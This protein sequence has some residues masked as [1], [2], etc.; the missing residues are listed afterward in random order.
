[1]TMLIDFPGRVT[2]L[3]LAP[4]AGLEPL[5]EAISNAL[6]AIESRSSGR[7]SIRIRV[8][9]DSTAQLPLGDLAA[10]TT[11][12]IEDTGVGFTDENYDSFQRCDTTY[13][14]HLGGK[15]VGR[16]FWL[17]AFKQVHVSRF[18]TRVLTDGV[19]P[20]IHVSYKHSDQKQYFKLGRGLRTE[21]T[22][23]DPKD[24]G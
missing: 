2:N 7:R 21:H 20:T 23:N 15:G 3:Q 12:H 11:F 8:D 22:M 24:F 1:M 6:H 4:K 5:F 17:K 14:A 19:T 9:R 18:R 16:L 13:K 10:I